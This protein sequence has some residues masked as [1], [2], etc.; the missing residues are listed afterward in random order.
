MC[1]HMYNTNIYERIQ[2][3]LDLCLPGQR[4]ETTRE[5]N[6][7]NLSVKIKFDFKNFKGEIKP[8]GLPIGAL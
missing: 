2:D 5:D 6:H 1:A 3:K 4:E 8:Y 7:L